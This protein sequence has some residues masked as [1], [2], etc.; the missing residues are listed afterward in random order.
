MEKLVEYKSA[1]SRINI[2]EN[3]FETINPFTVNVCISL[4]S[5]KNL[6]REYT[7]NDLITVLD[8]KELI[9]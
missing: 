6:V 3:Y 2:S 4:F 1:S 7:E 5:E 8:P 9:V